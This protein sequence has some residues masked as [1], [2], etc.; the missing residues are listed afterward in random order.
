MEGRPMSRSGYSDD[1][2]NLW[3]WR[4]AVDRALNGKRG[5]A[6][7]KELLAAMEAM[8][9]KRLIADD[10]ESHGDVCALGAVGK[11]RGIDMSNLDPDDPGL[12]GMAF[13]IAPAMAA[14]IV[15]MNDEA[16]WHITPENRFEKMRAWVLDNIQGLSRKHGWTKRYHAAR[17]AREAVRP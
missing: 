14:E 13:G 11:A 6:F 4:G 12:V 3:L 9:V 8:P 16:Y 10:L 7:L 15:Y 17:K 1:C 5:Q 2:E